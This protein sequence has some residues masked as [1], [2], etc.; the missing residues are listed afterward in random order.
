MRPLILAS[1][2]PYRA[3]LL[4]RLTIEFETV[5]PRV[6][7]R[8]DEGE[9]PAHRA[10][11]LAL[12]KANTVAAL[13]PG[14]VVIGSDQVA[15]ITGA[16]LDKPGSQARCVSQL[17][18]LGGRTA[19]FY[20]ACAVVDAENETVLE[21]LDETA[22]SFRPLTRAEILRYVER[23]R[24]FDCAGGFKAEGLGVALFERMRTT[25]PTALIGLPLIWLAAALRRSGYPLP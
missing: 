8:H 18:R 19:T 14:A 13:R 25:D 24:P 5:N 11:R 12:E 10:R 4:R 17:E 23:E 1:T 3:E 16:I 20:T 21:H 15:A 22:V 6:K 2:S 7:E 9:T